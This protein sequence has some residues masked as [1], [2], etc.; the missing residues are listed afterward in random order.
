V[1]ALGRPPDV[2]F[3]GEEYG[4]RYAELMGARHVATDRAR[5]PEPF[6]GTAIRANPQAHLDWLDP[7]VRAHY[8]ARVCV[9]G[10]ESTGK[11]SLARDLSEHYG[12]GF[13]GEFG[14][15]Y[16]EA[17]PDPSRY[18]WRTSDFRLIA[19]AQAALE[20]DAARWAPAPLI[21]D[22]NP[23]VTA[24]FHEAYLGRTDPELEVAAS[25]RPYH[26]LVVC[27][28]ET[29]FE[30]DHTGL[31]HEGERRWWM[32]R[33][34]CDYAASNG[35]TAVYV[36]GSRDERRAQAAEAVDGLIGR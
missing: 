32:H 10:A 8:V 28:P 13:V 27:D 3:T 16:T 15:F 4:P 18:R 19:A 25:A 7:H 5:E 11:T 17:M 23:F 30:Q 36:T 35:A 31:R 6:N 14:R 9:I 26:L 12:V 24:V 22:T 20:D 34:Y 33:R 29:P 2:V 1:R 21:C